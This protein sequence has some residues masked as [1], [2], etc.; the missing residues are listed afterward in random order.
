MLSL[1]NIYDNYLVFLKSIPLLDAKQTIAKVFISLQTY[2][3][4]NTS[5]GLLSERGI[6]VSFD[7][8]GRYA[9]AP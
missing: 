9:A 1:V 8:W 7:S 6:G 3:A 5:P 4:K 2:S